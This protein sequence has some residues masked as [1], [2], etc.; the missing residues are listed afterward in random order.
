MGQALDILRNSLANH[1]GTNIHIS[2]YWIYK[3]VKN[4]MFHSVSCIAEN[5]CETIV[6]PY[7]LHHF[8]DFLPKE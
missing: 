5:L 4:Y 2:I 1:G 8:P 3:Y 7:V 6:I